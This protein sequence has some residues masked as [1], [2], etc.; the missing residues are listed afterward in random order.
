[1]VDFFVCCHAAT[2]F[3]FL[4]VSGSARPTPRF[5]PA[6]RGPAR[7]ARPALPSLKLTYENEKQKKFQNGRS[8][9]KT[10]QILFV[11]S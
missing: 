1:V 11:F 5:L 10:Y 4:R 2:N 3:F 6:G 8:E 9:I 7:T